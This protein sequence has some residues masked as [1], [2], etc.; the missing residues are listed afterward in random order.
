MIDAIKSGSPSDFLRCMMSFP[1]AFGESICLTALKNCSSRN[2][3]V[4]S[5]K[6]KNIT[7]FVIKKEIN[8]KDIH[9]RRLCIYLLSL[10]K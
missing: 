1:N 6:E 2:A 9:K 10:S 5:Q 7:G 8:A 3:S 4:N